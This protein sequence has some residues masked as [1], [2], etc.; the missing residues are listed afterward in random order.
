MVQIGLLDWVLWLVYFVL[1]GLVLFVYQNSKYTQKDYRLFILGYIIKVFGG[2][3]FVM[4]FMY[5]YGFG[6]TFLYFDGARTLSGAI[7][8]DPGSY[9]QLIFSDAGNLP[10]RLSDFRELIPYSRT[11]EEWFMVKLISPLTFISFNSYLVLTLLMSFISFLGSWRL[12]RVFNDILP[13]RKY[14]NFAA[15]FVVPSMIFWGSGILKDTLTLAAFNFLIYEVYFLSE[16]RKF[17]IRRILMIIICAYLIF[18]L[19]S[20]ILIAFVPSMAFIF[21]RY[22]SE[23]LRS[24]VLK[25]ALKPFLIILFGLFVFFGLTYLG[26]TSEK[27]SVEGLEQQ[28]KGFHSWHT[29]TAGSAYSLGDVEYSFLGVVRKIPASLEVT[30]FRPYFWETQNTV[31]DV[32]A[33]EG[34]LTFILILLVFIRWKFNRVSDLL[35]NGFLVGLLI[36]CLIFAV[37]IGFTSYNF[38]ALMR[39]KIPISSLIFF[40]L[41]YLNLDPVKDKN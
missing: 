40:I 11:P 26:E 34:F 1:I 15:A 8:E 16:N 14:W 2:L 38:G 17:S 19:K 13:N 32:S 9:L 31:M 33:L 36:Y 35:K 24:S 18:K 28:A 39:Y 23:T 21:Y 6:D 25:F 3:S 20:Y 41:I 5:Y 27:Y 37:A 4:I 29:T 7:I 10:P 22:L 12:F 30:F